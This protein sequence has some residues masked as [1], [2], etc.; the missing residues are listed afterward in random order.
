[1]PHKY[2]NFVFS[3]F[4]YCIQYSIF[5]KMLRKNLFTPKS[6]FS[7]H[8]KACFEGGDIFCTALWNALFALDLIR[9]LKSHFI[10]TERIVAVIDI[11]RCLVRDAFFMHLMTSRTCF[12]HRCKWIR[13]PKGWGRG[14]Q[15][16]LTPQPQE[17]EGC[18]EFTTDAAGID[19]NPFGWGK[20]RGVILSKTCHL[21]KYVTAYGNIHLSPSAGR[22]RQR[23]NRG[24]TVSSRPAWEH[25]RSCFKKQKGGRHQG[26]LPLLRSSP[27][28]FPST[29]AGQL[30][31]VYNSSSRAPR[32]L[33]SEIIGAQN[34]PNLP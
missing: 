24:Y 3:V 16:G 6:S 2:K 23:P 7:L 20:G 21:S 28:G 30:T 25:A 32:P 18:V 19:G 31:A 22:Q 5:H 33:T 27:A 29:Q 14:Q 26:H 4:Q 9:L 13:E 8:F 15:P 1:M 17:P 12:S 10:R 34:R 11:L